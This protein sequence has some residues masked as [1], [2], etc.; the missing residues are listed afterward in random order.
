[1]SFKANTSFSTGRNASRGLF[2]AYVP[3]IG[4]GTG[5][6][7]YLSIIVQNNTYFL[8]FVR[9]NYL[10]E[11]LSTEY[12]SDHS[13]TSVHSRMI[14]LFSYLSIICYWELLN[15]IQEL[16][17][18]LSK[19]NLGLLALEK[20]LLSI[21]PESLLHNPSKSGEYVPKHQVDLLLKIKEKEIQ[22]MKEELKEEY[23]RK[24][25]IELSLTLPLLN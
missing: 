23:D 6:M 8:L 21:Q 3:A 15:Q 9:K 11:G 4:L 25:S 24:V 22:D 17:L 20:L 5:R 12:A 19:H 1:M 7:Q 16:K 10:E 2:P 14:S 13:Q 18:S